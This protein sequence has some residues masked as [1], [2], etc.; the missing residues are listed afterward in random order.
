MHQC[1]AVSSIYTIS[2][3]QSVAQTQIVNSRGHVLDFSY[4][5]ARYD[6]RHLLPGDWNLGNTK[7]L[8]LGLPIVLSLDLGSLDAVRTRDKYPQICEI[9]ILNPK[10]ERFEIRSQTHF[11]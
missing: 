8:G 6:S 10:R 1:W 3:T 11:Y 4:V 9:P 5:T 7:I 2:Q